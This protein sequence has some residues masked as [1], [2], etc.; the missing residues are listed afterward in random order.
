LTIGG[1]VLLHSEIENARFSASDAWFRNGA[2]GRQGGKVACG[3]RYCMIVCRW[4]RCGM[5][6]TLMGPHFLS[7]NSL[8]QNRIWFGFW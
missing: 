7:V 3:G 2:D 1:A 5:S 6:G 4:I 8:L